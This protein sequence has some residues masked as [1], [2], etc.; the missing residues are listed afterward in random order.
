MKVRLGV[1]Y[2]SITWMK[3]DK[4]C[5]GFDLNFKIALTCS[6]LSRLRI[7]ETIQGNIALENRL[8]M[9]VKPIYLTVM[10]FMMTMSRCTITHCHILHTHTADTSL[11]S[12]IDR[13][14]TKYWMGHQT[15]QKSIHFINKPE[16][17]H[18]HTNVTLEWLN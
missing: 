15:R 3:T 11:Y 7:S 5:K 16:S 12:C 6:R 2:L 4:S 14:A 1:A 13:F 8:S 17:K 9:A 18:V 10:S